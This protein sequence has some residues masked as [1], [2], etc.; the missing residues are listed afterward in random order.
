MKKPFAIML[1]AVI[2]FIL[3]MQF[4]QVM[5]I[6]AIKSTRIKEDCYGF[7]T[8]QLMDEFYEYIDDQDWETADQ[9]TSELMRTGLCELFKKGEEVYFTE[10]S[11]GSFSAGDQP[12]LKKIHR[13]GSMREYWVELGLPEYSD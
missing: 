5:G 1:S 4:P 9:F 11:L 13:K 10:S 6:S 2:A 12:M 3:V 7:L 8:L